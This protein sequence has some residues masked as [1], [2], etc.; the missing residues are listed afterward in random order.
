MFKLRIHCINAQTIL[1]FFNAKVLQHESVCA[2][3]RQGTGCAIA[4]P[5]GSIHYPTMQTVDVKNNDFNKG[6]H[7]QFQQ[8]ASKL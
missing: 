6:A 8:D 7:S 1:E 2:H 3:S 5:N 4:K